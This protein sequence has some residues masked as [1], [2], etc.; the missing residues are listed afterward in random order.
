MP[1][2]GKLARQM[3]EQCFECGTWTLSDELMPVLDD[4]RKRQVVCGD[5][6]KHY[7][8]EFAY[9]KPGRSNYPRVVGQHKEKEEL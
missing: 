7:E 5:C 4:D 9:N 1:L 8:A 6:Y 2:T 3:S